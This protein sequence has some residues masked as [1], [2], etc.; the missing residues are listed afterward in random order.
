MRRAL[1]VLTVASIFA[2]ACAAPADIAE[3]PAANSEAN[4]TA[5]ST[6]RTEDTQ[7]E[8]SAADKRTF[9]IN[10]SV[11]MNSVESDLVNMVNHS[12]DGLDD[13][14]NHYNVGFYA[15][16]A[17][18]VG[19]DMW[20]TISVRAPEDAKKLGRSIDKFN[21]KLTEYDAKFEEASDREILRGLEDLVDDF[22]DIQSD[23]GDYC[24][25]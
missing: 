6:E 16:V 8:T 25:S 21:E 19:N 12:N 13:P 18:S 22:L 3:E 10:L 4:Q 23:V 20:S 2:V 7:P 14:L 24:G 15:H 5:N 1:L 9:C 11:Y 17:A